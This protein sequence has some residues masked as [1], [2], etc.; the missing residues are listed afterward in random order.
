MKI[1]VILTSA[2]LVLLAAF[3][4]ILSTH[5]ASAANAARAAST[6]AAPSGE[7]ADA[8][9]IEVSR[10]H[11]RH[12]FRG[13]G[14]FKRHKFGGGHWGYKRHSHRKH[15]WRRHYYSSSPF[16]SF[17]FGPSYYDD[18]YYNDYE[19]NY[20]YPASDNYGG[21]CGRW[22]QECA[23]NWGYKTSDYYGCLKYHRCE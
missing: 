1:R 18:Y 22:Q 11:G 13:G 6:S 10:R 8:G 20:D 19:D 5:T 7:T 2:F 3:G 4:F 15:R 23:R 21:A 16:F 12:H 14:H 9:L 17:Y